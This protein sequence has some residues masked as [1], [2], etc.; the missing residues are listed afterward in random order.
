MADNNLN[1]EGN[2]TL[3]AEQINS[4]QKR[5]AIHLYGVAS[6]EEMKVFRPAINEAVKK[7]NTEVRKLEER[8]TYGKAFLQ[9]TNLWLKD[10]AVRKFT[11]NKK[12]ASIAAQLLGVEKVRVYHD[13]ALYKEAGGGATPW[14]Q[15]QYYWP[16]AT[17]KTIT[18]WMP[19]VDINVSM[20]MLTFAEGS[21]TNGLVNSIPISDESQSL[22][23][24]YVSEKDY[25][26]YRPD[27][28]AAGDATFHYGYTL[29][30]AP[31]NS[32]D[33]MREVMT[34]IYYEDGAV[35]T[36]PAND[37]Q[38]SDRIKWFDGMKPGK[39]AASALNPVV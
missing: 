7:N 29:H 6:P 34:I 4:F 28:M 23:D 30:K 11:L 25:P 36:E 3:S 38:E 21:H 35:I 27:S 26:I 20:G 8:D 1:Q 5:G 19:L 15:D 18:M 39:L 2:F 24:A 33:Q 13:Q 37:N 17:T 12:F 9:I 10:E 31:G 22:L 14:H 32:S 16:L